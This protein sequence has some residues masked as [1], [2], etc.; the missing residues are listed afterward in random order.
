L[1]FF[2]KPLRVAITGIPHRGVMGLTSAG[3][4]LPRHRLEMFWIGVP[5][6]VRLASGS[7]YLRAKTR[8]GR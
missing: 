3:H 4:A 8:R 7:S 2:T 6:A 5:F 1:V